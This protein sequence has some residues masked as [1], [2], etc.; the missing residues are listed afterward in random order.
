MSKMFS[1]I[2][3]V[4]VFNKRNVQIVSVAYFEYFKRFVSPLLSA[5]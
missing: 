1:Y 2:A 5:G 4:D 3:D